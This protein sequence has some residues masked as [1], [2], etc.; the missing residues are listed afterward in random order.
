LSDG[1]HV[2]ASLGQASQA[3]PAPTYSLDVPSDSQAVAAH[4]DQER[5]RISDL[6]AKL[7]AQFGNEKTMNSDLSLHASPAFFTAIVDGLN[8]VSP[9]LDITLGNVSEHDYIKQA[10]GAFGYYVELSGRNSLQ[11]RASIRGFRASWSSPGQVAIAADFTFAASAQLAYHLK[12]GIGGG[13]GGSV[14]TNADKGGAISGSV[15]FSTDGKKWPDYEILLTGPPSMEVTLS[16]QIGRIGGIG[17]PV[18]FN[19]P[20]GTLAKGSAPALFS[21]SGSLVLPLPNG[22]KQARQYTLSITPQSSAFDQ[23]GFT[24]TAKVALVWQ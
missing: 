7:E 11:A 22:N 1:I 8:S 21:Q 17:I 6:R 18:K 19:L 9:P 3:V 5:K 10:G 2:A 16:A 15:N 20:V 13:V 23:N 12:T 24:T 14:G 4:L